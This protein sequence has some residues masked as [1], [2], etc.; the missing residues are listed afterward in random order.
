VL[1]I[2][3]P[4]SASTSLMFT[5]SQAL[6]IAHKNGQ[7]ARPR[8]TRL[9]CYTELQKYHG[10]MVLRE[11]WFLKKYI[12]DEKI[13][14]KEHILPTKHHLGIILK[15]SKP[16]V[17]LLRDAADCIESYRRVF[18]VLPEINVCYDVMR[19]E[20]ETFAEK[21][22]DAANKSKLF[23]LVNYNDLIDD[24]T[25]VLE[26]IIIHYGFS[27]PDGIEKIKLAKKNYTWSRF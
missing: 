3:Q 12:K 2:A 1:L 11:E 7:N 18:S 19:Q 6:K 23:L 13:I 4:K 9:N 22:R 27:I 20:L 10:T 17:V 26:K 21:Y 15:I 24:F 5:L 16:V 25:K 8:D 14:F